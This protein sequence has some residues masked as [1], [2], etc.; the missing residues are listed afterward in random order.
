[1]ASSRRPASAPDPASSPDPG[2]GA[3]AEPGQGPKVTVSLREMC[4]KFRSKS[5]LDGLT[6]D[7][8]SGEIFGVVGPNGSGKTT[9]LR[10]ICRA[11]IPTAGSVTVLGRDIGDYSNKEFA[12]VVSALLPQWPS[13]FSMK[14]YEII[15]MGC[16]NRSGGI[17][18]DSPAEYH[19]VYEVLNLLHAEDLAE[20]DFETLSSGEQRKVLLAKSLVQQTDIVLLDEPVA[21]LDLKHKL[22]VMEVL[23]YLADRGKTVI[24]SLHELDLASKYCHNIIVLKGGRVVTA[25]KPR[26]VIT[27]DLLREVYEVEAE[28]RWDDTCNYPIIIPKLPA[29]G[30]GNGSGNGKDGIKFTGSSYGYG[31]TSERRDLCPNA[32]ARAG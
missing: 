17:W 16:R 24:T 22:E 3:A 19:S 12:G 2:P 7:V 32:K 1:M 14:A 4:M 31:K 10:C 29:N 18:W 6:L 30:S 28:V 13:G 11:L 20:R 8:K 15:L 25:G 21:F 9:L 26:E 23:K 27:T 5:A